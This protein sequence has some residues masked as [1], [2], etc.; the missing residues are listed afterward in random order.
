MN[1]LHSDLNLYFNKYSIHIL[2]R[3]QSG[4]IDP[5]KT[6]RFC[7]EKCQFFSTSCIELIISYRMHL[8]RVTGN[9]GDSSCSHTTK[10]LQ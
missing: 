10:V 6:N 3:P 2:D 7:T 1:Q 9:K 4:H 8:I 5:T